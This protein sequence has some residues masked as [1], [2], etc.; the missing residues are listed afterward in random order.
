MPFDA[1]R[2]VLPRS[3]VLV[4]LSGTG[5]STVAPLLADRFGVDVVDLDRRIERVAGRP[6]SW[7][8]AEEGED[9]FRRVELDVLGDVLGEAPSVVAS[10]GGVVCT[11][12][13]RSLLAAH[14]L[15]VWL[16]APD[17][18]L[19][20]RLDDPDEPRPLLGDDPANTLQRLRREREAWYAEL[21][22]LRVPVER[23][24]PSQVADAVV[25]G[26]RGIGV[27]S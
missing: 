19:V 16:D 9:G 3:L 27:I 22:G 7:I 18:L 11:A 8:F 13:A 23:L 5:K 14:A 4:G 15:V 10:G 2:P 12:E 17:A 26:L 24:D 6:V 21:A 25:E 20:E 1:P